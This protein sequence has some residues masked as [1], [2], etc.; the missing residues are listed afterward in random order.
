MEELAAAAAV[1]PPRHR[2]RRR[3]RRKASST[4][5]AAR[6][7]YGDVFGGP[8][9]FAAP[10]D[11][12]PADYGEVFGGVA[13][14]CS[15]P[16]LDLPPAAVRDDGA[17]AGGYG[18]IFGRFD[19]GDFAEPYED[20]LAEA[21][22]LAAEIASSSESS[23]SSVR[24]ES[25]LLDAEPSILHQHYPTVGYD[26]HF[27][28]E[29]FSPI[30]SPPDSG[31][32]FNMSYNK[33]TRGR[34]DDIVKMTTCMV[35]PSISYVVDSCNLSNKSATDHVV[36][37]DS[38]TFANG[39]KGSM[40]QTFPSS[41][42]VKSAS[43]DSMA[44]QNLHTPTCHPISK[45]DC[46]DE[47]DHNRLSTHS[48][49]SE[50]VPSP[51]YPFLRVSNNSLHTQPI[52]VQPPSMPPS[53]LL[54][55]KES[56]TNGD[57]EVSTNSA[58]AAAAIKEA[59]EFA[60]ARLKA[61]KELME[62]KGDTFKLRKKP[63]H[64]RGT[65][66]TELKES[67]TP[68]EVHVYDEKL[69]MRRLVKEEKT[70]EE[71]ALVTKNGDSSAVKLNHCDHNEKVVL[72]TRKPQQTAQHG[73]KLEQLGK[74]TSGAEFYE[75]ISLDQKCKTNSVTCE[76][77]NVQTANP[78]SKLGQ[79][80]KG[81]GEATSGDLERSVKSWDGVD[82]TELRME[83]VNLREYATG[84]MEDGCKASRAPEVSF[85]KEKPTHQE[86]TKT[87]F[88]ECVGTQNYQGHDDDRRFEISCVNGISSK[89]QAP[90]ISSASLE[91]CISGGHCNGNK[92]PSDAS[93]EETTPL[94]KSKKENNNIE[95]L[96]VPCADEMRSQIFQEYHEVCNENIDEIKASQAKVS[97]L[98]ELVEHYETPNFQTQLSAAHGETE[99][100]EKEKMFSFSDELC[101]QNENEGITKIP[102]ES[103]IHEENKKFGTEEKAYITL[104]K[105]V[106]QKSGSLGK[107]AN[108]TSETMESTSAN[109][110]EEAEVLNVF[111]EGI[112]LMT[113]HVRTCGTSV[114]Y[115]DQIQ[116]PQGSLG[117]Q[118]SEN[119]MDRIGDL[120]CHGN[121]EG[122]DPW[123]DNSDKSQVEEILSHDGKEGKTSVEGGIDKGPNDAYAEVNV[124]NDGNVNV[125][126]SEIEVIIDDD[127]DCNMKLNTCPKELNASFLEP[128]ASMQNLSQIDESISVQTSD[129]STPLENLGEDCRKAERE[130]SIE[131]CTAL[132]VQGQGIGSKM[133]GDAKYKLLKLKQKDQKS[134]NLDSNI[135]PKFT[136]NTTLN[137][138]QKLRDETPPDFQRIE[139]REN[140]KRT[141][142][143]T[144]KVLPRLDED[145]E[146]YNMEREK[147]QA[148]ER[149]RLEL[150][151]E[152]ERERERAKDRLAVQRATKEAHD[153]AFAE[154]RAKA[155][156]IA[157]ER[158]TLARQR[159]SAEA[160]EKEEK[161]SAEAA[162]EKASR[163]ARLKAERAAVERATAE[164]RERAIEK[165]K[166]AADAKE[167]MERFKSSFKD[168][169]K[170]TN[171]ENQLDKQFQRTASNN[172]ARST[173]SSNQ[174]VEFESALRHK[175]RSEREQRTAERAA[176]ALAEK[177][178]RDMLA[179][180][181]QAERHRLA[182]FLDPEVK[183]WSNGKEGNLRALLSTLQYILGSDSG[184]QSVPLT[185]LITATAVKKAYR[186]ATL[187]VHPDKLQQRGATIRQKYICEK[188]FDL[189]KI[190]SFIA[191]A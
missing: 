174:V 164:A 114:E 135:V 20:L 24:K 190:G 39:E 131:N 10:F 23:R 42:S 134:V 123:S 163:E 188:V 81:K 6:A 159:A 171:Q 32:Q 169:F 118:H 103:L 111:V 22:A 57:S 90:E 59:M 110:N 157:L 18:E 109:R 64:H 41:S 142:R 139:G 49:S 116:E 115:P 45:N 61:A 16:Y 138:V 38:D 155:E 168:S 65:K 165:A 84:S 95:A 148:K 3:H 140:V 8:P 178:M 50:D 154:A 14:S 186:R 97:K 161:A 147:E 117:P 35:E 88:K 182:E 73:S 70:Y 87:Y 4:D 129:E 63:G 86:S 89:L 74:W 83:H 94:G 191:G 47:D 79:F 85:G 156:R 91:S 12:V 1:P 31:K 26:Q 124:R 136:E 107:E 68:E 60:E 106:V 125:H 9:Q 177:N 36:V 19:F 172:Y 62:R 146:R 67:T 167:R 17:R 120:V 112:N 48:A 121:E 130:F 80:E 13:A 101:P 53:K 5:A 54:N 122:K 181:E 189:L 113:T 29:E 150:E 151:E 30:S 44:D 76:G 104:E 72:P 119:R 37:V 55:K 180:R 2:E 75:L 7:G 170:A 137:Y 93:T 160:R 15:I 98:E 153:R 99:T 40:G 187:C 149:S 43:S 183:R 152:K 144:E 102:R 179:Q 184:W 141:E 128:C 143:E 82:I 166:A 78:S 173:D 34:P 46:E 66:L 92:N 175:A 176:K 132:E 21:V 162:T 133:E 126:H 100:V 51:D 27:D 127:S 145:K 58:A 77:D 105:D 11:G 96:E 25:G 56:K 28:E 52:K 185:D 69:T 108:I 71:P 33:A 158:I